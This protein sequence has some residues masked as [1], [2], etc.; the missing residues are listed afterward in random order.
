VIGLARV[1]REV[2]NGASVHAGER[3]AVVTELPFGEVA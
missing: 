2:E 1:R 3:E